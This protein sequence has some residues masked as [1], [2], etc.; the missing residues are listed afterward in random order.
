M[1][2]GIIN[3]DETEKLYVPTWELN[4]DLELLSEQGSYFVRRELKKARKTKKE[5]EKEFKIDLAYTKSFIS[6]N[7][8]LKDCYYEIRNKIA[9]T[10][11]TNPKIELMRILIR[12]GIDRESKTYSV[13]YPYGMSLINLNLAERYVELLKDCL[14]DTL[15]KEEIMK[16]E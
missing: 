16:I 6:A 7:P 10:R 13:L 2:V 9:H 15:L 14:A 8:H 1:V 3:Y 4:P 12:N 11:Y 5:Y